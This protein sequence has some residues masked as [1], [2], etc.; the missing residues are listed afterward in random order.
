MPERMHSRM[1]ASMPARLP[2]RM[3]V[4]V[5]NNIRKRTTP[6]VH[7]AQ[8]MSNITINIIISAFRIASY[9]L[10]TLKVKCLKST[11]TS[12]ADWKEAD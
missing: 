11:S 10:Q 4:L 3:P 12:Q 5:N 7:I 9:V 1:P 6:K 2:A 8:K